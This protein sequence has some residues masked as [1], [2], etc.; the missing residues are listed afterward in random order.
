M[1]HRILALL[2]L[3]VLSIVWGLLLVVATLVQLSG[4]VSVLP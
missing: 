3:G 1:I 4:W 2:L